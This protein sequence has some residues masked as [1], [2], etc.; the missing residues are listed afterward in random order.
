MAVAPV[1][2]RWAL[3]LSGATILTVCWAIGYGHYFETIAPPVAW[4]IVMAATLS[5]SPTIVRSF[6]NSDPVQF[7]GRISYSTYLFH[8]PVIAVV[9]HAVWQWVHPGNQIKLLILTTIGSV[10]LIALVSYLA[11]RFIERPG[12]ELGHRETRRVNHVAI[13]GAAG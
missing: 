2:K 9:Q 3:L 6:L 1:A 13:Q 12:Q 7:L 8:G 4:L 11:W 5:S 10:P